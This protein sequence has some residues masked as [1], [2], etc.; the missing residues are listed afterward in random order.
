MSLNF[1]SATDKCTIPSNS[2]IEISLSKILPCDEIL[3]SNRIEKKPPV[4]ESKN[5]AA[6]NSFLNLGAKICVVCLF[7]EVKDFSKIFY[8]QNSLDFV[9]DKTIA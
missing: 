4:Q 8:S 2:T 3:L 6:Q 1:V 9:N 5:T 7:D